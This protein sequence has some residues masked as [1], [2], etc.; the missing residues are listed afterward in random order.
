MI[1]PGG[2]S[3]DEDDWDDDYFTSQPSIKPNRISSPIKDLSLDEQLLDAVSAK[4][5]V[6][7]QE[8]LLMGA[9]VGFKPQ[10]NWNVTIMAS[11]LGHFKILKLFVDRGA[12]V[13]YSYERFTPLLAL[14]SSS[15]RND[16]ELL[17]CLD[18]LITTGVEINSLD[19][20]RLSPLSHAVKSNHVSLVYRLIEKGAD[21]NTADQD[22]CTPL[23]YAVNSGNAHLVSLLKDAGADIYVINRAGYSLMDV[24]LEKDYHD[25]VK[26]LNTGLE[27]ITWITSFEDNINFKNAYQRIISA[28][29]LKHDRYSGYKQD[30]FNLM[31]AIRLAHLNE[32]FYN[33]NI[34]FGHLLTSD[35]DKLKNVGIKFW[36]ERRKILKAVD[37]FHE[38]PWSMSSFG[39]VVSC[40]DLDLFH[41]AQL[42]ATITRQ[43]Y[44]I[45]VS[46]SW[47]ITRGGM[48]KQIKLLPDNLN[49]SWK[50][51][52]ILKGKLL[53]LQ[54]KIR[55]I[56]SS[57]NILPS[58]LIL[59]EKQ[60]H[61]AIHMGVIYCTAFAGLFLCWKF[62]LISTNCFSRR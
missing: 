33:N 38:Y 48:D 16:E 42:M 40:K 24:A 51:T 59:P 12:D 3:S 19:W 35:E 46:I 22:A 9:D 61:K 44:I 32:H 14:C 21:V 57:H 4:D 11:S 53:S 30:V 28:L 49:T 1:R 60:H 58:D 18:L 50:T 20:Y 36:Y 45:S 7:V 34:G 47:L 6:K 41:I 17:K 25:I 26:I 62:K 31:S 55:K 39:Y 43:L 23:F 8:L 56:D 52:R 5:I 54:A 13:N 10:N 27:S 2:M 15:N 37:K 29:P